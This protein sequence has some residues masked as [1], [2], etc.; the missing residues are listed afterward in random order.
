MRE[1]QQTEIDRKREK[2][3]E[4]Q[5]WKCQEAEVHEVEYS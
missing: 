4:T 1:K 2:K 3:S 5:K